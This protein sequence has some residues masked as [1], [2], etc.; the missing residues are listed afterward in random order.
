MCRLL[1]LDYFQRSKCMED[2]R[3]KIGCTRKPCTHEVAPPP[4]SHPRLIPIIVSKLLIGAPG[5]SSVSFPATWVG[6]G[7]INA[8]V[9]VIYLSGLIWC[10]V[11]FGYATSLIIGE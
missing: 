10:Q 3:G 5:S 6:G 9:E 4:P 7:F 8:T 2:R 11:P 1:L